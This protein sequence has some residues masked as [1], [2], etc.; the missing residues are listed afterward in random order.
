[1]MRKE[2]KHF[3]MS[4]KAILMVMVVFGTLFSSCYTKEDIPVVQ[5]PEEVP[6]KYIIEGTIVA[7]NNGNLETLKGVTVTSDKN[8]VVAAGDA[9]FIVTVAS[10]DTYTLSLSK[11][12]YDPISYKVVVPSA[13]DK[14]TGQL[15]AVNV[16]LTMYRENTSNPGTGEVGVEGGVVANG[17]GELSIPAGA[18]TANTQITMTVLDDVKQA[19]EVNGTQEAAA[20]FLLGEFG[21]SGTKFLNPVQWS[22]AYDA[23]SEYYLANTQLQY[24]ANNNAGD[25]TVLTDGIVY[26]NDK[27]NVSLTH[28]SQY[29]MVYMASGMTLDAVSE[30]LPAIA[31]ITN[32]NVSPASISQI[33]YKKFEGAEL[34]FGDGWSGITNASDKQQIEELVKNAIMAKVNVAEFKSSIGAAVDAIFTL[35][36]PITL[37]YDYHLLSKGEQS[38]DYYVFT[39]KVYK[40]SDDSAVELKANVK[41]AGKV[42][43]FVEMDYC[44]A[45]HTH[46]SCGHVYHG[47]AGGGMVIGD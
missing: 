43:I 42:S 3:G 10:P 32:N 11:T 18:L 5:I 23:L 8:G 20:Q 33:P 19:V 4:A 44:G 9:N 1:M 25:W 22:V 21:P 6:N 15:I 12:G 27:Y 46:G 14:I 39:F 38:M 35:R 24:R 31:A 28:F 26:D 29:R 17:G 47:G 37:P 2:V 34:T 13:G 7:N 16:Q 40:I 30:T 45:H 36:D 41:V